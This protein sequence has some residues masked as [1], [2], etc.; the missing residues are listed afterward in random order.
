MVTPQGEC[1]VLDLE[2]CHILDLLFEPLNRKTLAFCD[3]N[4]KV[5]DMLQPK[6]KW[7]NARA[8]IG[9]SRV[10]FCQKKSAWNAPLFGKFLK[11]I[12]NLKSIF[13]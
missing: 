4:V 2:N 9:N 10:G 13:K 1:S 8:N 3:V 5:W 6:F 7:F 12:L 11:K